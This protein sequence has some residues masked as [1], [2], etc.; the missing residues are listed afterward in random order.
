MTK[1]KHFLPKTHTLL[2]HIHPHTPQPRSQTPS[3]F[4]THC[5]LTFTPQSHTHTAK[6][7][8][9]KRYMYSCMN[10][11]IYDCRTV[12]LV[13]TVLS[14]VLWWEGESSYICTH[15]KKDGWEGCSVHLSITGQQLMVTL[16]N[17]GTSRP[18]AVTRQ[19]VV[20]PLTSAN[21]IQQQCSFTATKSL[22]SQPSA[23]TISKVDKVL[24]KA[25]N[26]KGKKGS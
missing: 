10:S 7:S 21:T 14:S 23:H 24:L 9:H 17:N 26:K 18:P 20:T 1:M 25:V 4:I 16:V 2:T 22:N 12:N 3:A 15:C 5:S 6:P 19:V 8:T 13:N 11:A